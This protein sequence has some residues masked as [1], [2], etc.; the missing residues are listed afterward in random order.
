MDPI[1]ITSISNLIEVAEAIFRSTQTRRWFRGQK[2][3]DWDLLPKVR[4]GYTRQQEKYLTNLFYTRAR[5]RHAVC[6]ANDDYGGWLALMQ[7][8]GLPT[9]LLDWSNSPMI[10]AYFAT[11]YPRDTGAHVKVTDA[12]LWALEPHLLNTSQ[13]YERLRR[14]RRESSCYL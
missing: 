9:R 2:A 6:P 4:R 10:A 14:R 11:K 13:L 5:T 8:F 12:A 1:T 3:F 7:H